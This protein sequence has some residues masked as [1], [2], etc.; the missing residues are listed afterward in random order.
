MRIAGTAVKE[1][2]VNAR[3]LPANTLAGATASGPAGCAV[4]F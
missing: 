1:N 4:R 3:D 2:R